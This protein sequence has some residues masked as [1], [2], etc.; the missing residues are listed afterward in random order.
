MMKGTNGEEMQSNGPRG[1][2]A[3]FVMLHRKF[4]IGYPSMLFIDVVCKL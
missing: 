2:E 4:M 1:K 3:I